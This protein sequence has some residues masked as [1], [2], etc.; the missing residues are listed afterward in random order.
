MISVIVLILLFAAGAILKN[1]FS[2]LV[3]GKRADGMV[4]AMDTTLSQPGLPDSDPMYSPV[5]EFETSTGNLIRVSSRTAYPT[6]S[7]HVG[8]EIKV[9]YS[10]SNPKNAQF[11]TWK[12]FPLIPAG[13]VL[14]LV[15]FILLVWIAVILISNDPTLGDPFNILNTVIKDFQINPF[16]F[17]FI[18]L[19]SLVIPSCLLGTYLVSKDA[20]D[21]RTNGLKV[22]GVVIGSELQSPRMNDGSRGS[23]VFP[24]ITYKDP[25]GTQHTIR[26]SLA[27]P[28]SQL[29]IGD[30]VEIIFLSRHP[31]RGIVNTWDELYFAPIIWGIF[32]LGFLACLILVMKGTITL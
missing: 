4:V 5:V 20:V 17:P 27:K 13:M 6:A 24:M 3:S 12:E 32:L 10:P 1:P 19:M 7:T 29:R 8:D 30:R 15:L 14:V 11:L 2:L 16:R 18:F 22:T 23:G 31:G 26:R 21:F 9:A 25:T 28:L